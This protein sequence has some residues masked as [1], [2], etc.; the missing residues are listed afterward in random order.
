MSSDPMLGKSDIEYTVGSCVV[1]RSDKKLNLRSLGNLQ[2]KNISQ[3]SNR[4][5]IVQRTWRSVLLRTENIPA[6]HSDDISILRKS[7]WYSFFIQI[8]ALVWVPFIEEIASD[9]AAF[10]AVWNTG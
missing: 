7:A 5:K 2:K 4:G 3:V 1:V 10:S 9:A 8:I 6:S